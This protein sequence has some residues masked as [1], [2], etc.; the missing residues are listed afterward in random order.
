MTS[1]KGIRATATATSASA[2]ID[3]VHD[4]VHGTPEGDWTSAGIVSDGSY[5][6]PAGLISSFPVT[7][8]G[9]EWEIVPGLEIGD[10]SRA[11]IDAS[12]AELVQERDAVTELGLLGT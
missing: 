11:K 1:G 12:V 4:W 5:G 7:S 9:G 3:H 10:L 6:V 8:S 2:A